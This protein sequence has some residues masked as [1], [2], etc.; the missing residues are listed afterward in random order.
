M[1]ALAPIIEEA[2]QHRRRRHVVLSAATLAIAATVAVVLVLTVYG[3]GSSVASSSTKR[4]TEVSASTVLS[5]T[6]YMG[7]SCRVANSIACDRVGLAVWLRRPA[8]SVIATIVG[9]RVVLDRRGDLLY[10]RDKP[11]TAF[12]GF[13]R[14]AGIV[15]QMHVKPVEGS[16]V[17]TR[18][19]RTRI[20]NRPDMWFGARQTPEVRVRLAIHEPGGRTLITHTTVGLSP[21]WG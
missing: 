16:V 8:V 20:V 17:Y 10:P 12:D 5:R 13:L 21:G 6:P 19:G 3:A 18:R 7:V 14:P 4:A 15:S 1:S 11:R 9:R 2:W